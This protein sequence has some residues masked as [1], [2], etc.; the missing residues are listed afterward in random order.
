M[1]A[2]VTVTTEDSSS[3]DKHVLHFSHD[4]LRQ[5]GTRMGAGGGETSTELGAG[6]RGVDTAGDSRL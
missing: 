3:S 2:V 1:L 5:V 6:M 4:L